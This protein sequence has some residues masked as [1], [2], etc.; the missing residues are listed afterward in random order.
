MFDAEGNEYCE[1]DP[2][3]EEAVQDVF[4]DY[5]KIFSKRFEDPDIVLANVDEELIPFLFVI[6]QIALSNSNCETTELLDVFFEWINT[7]G[8]KT[9]ILKIF[10][11]RLRLYTDIIC[12]EKKPRY[13]WLMF[14]APKDTIDTIAR[15]HAVFGDILI[16]PT[17]ATNYENA[18]VV[19]HSIFKVK[20][21]STKMVD[22]YFLLIKFCHEVTSAYNLYHYE[23]PQQPAK[24]KRE[25]KQNE[26][27]KAK[28]KKERQSNTLIAGLVL[29]G[30]LIFSAILIVLKI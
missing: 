10:D 24:E 23:P 3:W 9:D 6:S 22:F 11:E 5:Y 19:L 18:P 7:L 4:S 30:V 15:C 28:P 2:T 13:E 26:K 20:E 25:T 8:L 17:C 1:I 27:H 29:V 21:F 16:N 14:N 12:N